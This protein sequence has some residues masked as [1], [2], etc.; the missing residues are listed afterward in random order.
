MT[1]PAAR[2]QPAASLEERLE[3]LRR[4]IQERSAPRR[5]PRIAAYPDGSFVVIDGDGQVIGTFESREAAIEALHRA[6]G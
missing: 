4:A 2:V 6:D 5:R 1:R 3:S